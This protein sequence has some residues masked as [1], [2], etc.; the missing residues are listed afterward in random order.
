MNIKTG[1]ALH[2]SVVLDDG[3]ILIMGGYPSFNDVWRSG[4]GGLTWS[5]LTNAAWSKGQSLFLFLSLSAHRKLML[6]N[7]ILVLR[8]SSHFS[9]LCVA[10]G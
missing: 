8:K 5:L 9:Y 1:R 6:T 4:D 10:T 2:K 7:S 3:S